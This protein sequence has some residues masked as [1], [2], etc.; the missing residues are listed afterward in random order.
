[1]ANNIQEVQRLL[2]HI[3]FEKSNAMHVEDMASQLGYPTG[4]SQVETRQLIRCAI[5]QGNIILTVHV[6]GYRRS[7]NKQ[8]VIDYINALL[9]RAYD[10][11][12][13]SNEIKNAWNSKNPNNLIQQ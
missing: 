5:Q 2:I 1:M 13:R 3:P 12:T 11:L 4:V 6:N 7:N 8:E 10:K 9:S